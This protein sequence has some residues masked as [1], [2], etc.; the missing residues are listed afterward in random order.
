MKDAARMF[1]CS[2]P[3]LIPLTT[4]TRSVAYDNPSP[5]AKTRCLPFRPVAAVRVELHEPDMAAHFGIA[6]RTGLLFAAS[7]TG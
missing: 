7:R 3:W 5:E 6:R 4:L 2:I 1:H